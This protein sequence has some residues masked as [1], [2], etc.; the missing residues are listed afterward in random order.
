MGIDKAKLIRK[1]RA[2]A[3]QGIDGEK[4]NAR[5]MLDKLL[6]KYNLS[7][8]EMDDNPLVDME[9]KKPKKGYECRLFWQIFYKL[10]HD[11]PEYTNRP[12]SN[13]DKSKFNFYEVPLA[14][15]IEF[16]ESWAVYSKAFKLDMD[17]FFLAFLYRNRLLS[18]RSETDKE[19][20]KEEIELHR[21]ASMMSMSLM[22][23]VLEK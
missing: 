19:P 15:K 9:V 22:N 6:A 5:E 20:T 16:L 18:P 17:Q 8:D 11:Y 13:R 4:Y 10:C 7:E 23:I 12:Y 1:I 21:K 2:L 14:F 3:N